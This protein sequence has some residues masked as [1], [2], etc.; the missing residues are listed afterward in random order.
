MIKVVYFDDYSAT[1]YL[2]IYD[3]GSKMNTSEQIK[4]KSKEFANKTSANLF[5]RLSWLPFIGGEAETGVSADFSYH[6][7]SLLKTTLSNTVLTD[8][9]E[10]IKGDTQRITKFNGYS[11]KA[12]KNSIAFF[13]MFTPYLKITKS[14]FVS[15]GFAFDLSRMDEAFESGKG[16]YELIADNNKGPKYVFRFNIEAFRNNYGIADLTKMDLTYYGIKV[17]RVDINLLDID[18]E[19][20]FE[21]GSISSAFDLE[22]EIKNTNEIDVYDV[23]LAG[24]EI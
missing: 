19:F 16:Y 5:A 13:K 24:V 9:L 18:K 3:G 12:Y 22:N 20:N 7:S 6:A 8:F 14:D 10:K 17:G 4:D 2:N 1:D 15:E 23:M 11:V 21:Q